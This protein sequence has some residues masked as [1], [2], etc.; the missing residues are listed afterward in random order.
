MGDWQ[1]ESLAGWV[2]LKPD[3]FTSIMIPGNTYTILI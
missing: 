1:G 2:T 3:P